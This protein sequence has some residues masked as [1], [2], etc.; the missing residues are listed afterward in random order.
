MV[1]TVSAIARAIVSKPK[2]IFADEPTSALD[3]YNSE[4]VMKL[5]FTQ[6]EKN[7]TTL[8]VY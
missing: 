2:V 7:N 8:I 4:K 5:L 6:A 3:D 1:A